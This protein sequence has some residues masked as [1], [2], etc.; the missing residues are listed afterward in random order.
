MSIPFKYPKLGQG[1]QRIINH[2]ENQI[3]DKNDL[4]KSGPVS[5]TLNEY[6]ADCLSFMYRHVHE[7]TTRS[8]QLLSLY[9]I[10]VE[11]GPPIRKSV[12]YIVV[13]DSEEKIASVTGIGKNIGIRTSSE[14]LRGSLP[15]GAVT[16]PLSIYQLQLKE[17]FERYRQVARVTLA[18]WRYRQGAVKYIGGDKAAIKE[19]EKLLGLERPS[20]P[21]TAFRAEFTTTDRP[22]SVL[23]IESRAPKKG[24]SYLKYSATVKPISD[25]PT[26]KEDEREI[27]I[28]SMKTVLG[29]ILRQIPYPTL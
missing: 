6:T 27:I 5:G 17:L 15:S 19:I 12:H 2:I 25:G 28:H 3:V 24:N 16:F 13:C 10:E 26:S 7:V 14:V 29:I 18:E 20:Y 8:D 23:M 4:D 21:V 11:Q 22:I 1:I 9:D